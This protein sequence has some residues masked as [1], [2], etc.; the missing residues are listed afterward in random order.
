MFN[1]TAISSLLNATAIR[2]TADYLR[3]NG[4]TWHDYYTLCGMSV[5]HHQL[6]YFKGECPPASQFATDLF[7]LLAR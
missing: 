2:A 1:A 5:T 4:Y 6:A 3:D 7:T